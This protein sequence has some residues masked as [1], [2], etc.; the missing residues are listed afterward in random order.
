MSPY[1]SNHVREI[2]TQCS[3]A[4]ILDVDNVSTTFHGRSD[5][6]R[7]DH[8]NKQSHVVSPTSNNLFLDPDVAKV[9]DAA[10]S[11]AAGSPIHPNRRAI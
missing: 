4:R 8:T 9:A 2:A 5:F 1:S 3:L 6:L 7:A 11:P 10:A